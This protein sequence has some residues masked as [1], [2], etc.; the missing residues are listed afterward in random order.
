MML[1]CIQII[2]FSVLLLCESQSSDRLMCVK[3]CSTSSLDTSLEKKY[4]VVCRIQEKK[5][6]AFNTKSIPPNKPKST[7]GDVEGALTTGWYLYKKPKDVYDSVALNFS[8]AP[9]QDGSVEYLQGY[10]ILIHHTDSSVLEVH[11]CLNTSMEFNKHVFANFYYD[12]YGLLPGESI[13]PGDSVQVI[14]TSLPYGSSSLNIEPLRL[15]INIPECLDSR[16]HN[17]TS[18]VDKR[19]FHIKIESYVCGK[20]F[21]NLS[22]FVPASYGNSAVV[23]LWLGA[24]DEKILSKS[25]LPILFHN[26][27]LIIPEKF[28]Y[29]NLSVWLSGDKV[30]T[31]HRRVLLT[32]SSCRNVISKTN[33]IWQFY[34]VPICAVFLILLC[35]CF[36]IQKKQ[37]FAA[38]FKA[39]NTTLC[40]KVNKEKASITNPNDP[41][42]KCEKSTNNC[43]ESSDE[44]VSIYVVFSDDHPEHTKV[45]LRFASLLHT[46]L[47]FKVTFELWQQDKIYEGCH[48]WMEKA[49]KECKK[50]L[51][52]WSPGAKLRWKQSNKTLASQQD[53]FTPVLKH[54]KK[55]LFYGKNVGKYFFAYFD[56]CS[57]SD[58]PDDFKELSHIRF[59]LMDQF[60]ELYFRLKNVEM[61]QPTEVRRE[62]K[63]AFDQYH[64]RKINQFGPALQ[65]SI[66]DMHALCKHIPCWYK[67]PEYAH[68]DS[69]EIA[70]SK[71]LSNSQSTCGFQVSQLAI[72]PP[73]PVNFHKSIVNEPTYAVGHGA[74]CHCDNCNQ[75]S[76]I[77]ESNALGESFVIDGDSGLLSNLGGSVTVTVPQ[78][79]L[80]MSK[81]KHEVDMSDK[82][83][84]CENDDL[85]TASD[86]YSTQLQS[87][88]GCIHSPCGVVDSG[89][90]TNSTHSP[91]SEHSCSIQPSSFHFEDEEE[92]SDN[93]VVDAIVSTS[94]TPS[95]VLVSP[96][97]ILVP[98]DKDTDPWM[99]LPSLN[100]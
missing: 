12:C 93:D 3:N 70:P 18:C 77:N 92:C 85:L 8:W 83:V 37:R 41:K 43:Q 91:P 44:A 86:G 50:V 61:F 52:I 32:S 28:L 47:G 78:F 89:F 9:T 34:V 45:V 40:Y 59:K 19:A 66:K 63:V 30:K 25:D 76:V 65:L 99:S 15:K 21:V 23:S 95:T 56:Y 55:D 16:M 38:K 48:A 79:S 11:Y 49:L 97:A 22:Y 68:K 81:Q 67:N 84:P 10:S 29:S 100:M 2:L 64:N 27:S 88:K 51:V 5:C 54:I 35:V 58:I 33:P 31:E 74:V 71:N 20:P 72:V 96:S 94:I 13:K 39:L 87:E 73:S 62:E 98:L 82:R 80:C 4:H 14:V 7:T 26:V 17:V 46:D 42:P 75:F 90:L 60:E 24:G 6:S 1:S 36:C 57:E 53:L 69:S